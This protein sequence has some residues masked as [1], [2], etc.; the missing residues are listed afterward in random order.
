MLKH[1][2]FTVEKRTETASDGHGVTVAKLKCWLTILL[3]FIKLWLDYNNSD[4]KL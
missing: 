3:H 4:L 1:A 2:Q